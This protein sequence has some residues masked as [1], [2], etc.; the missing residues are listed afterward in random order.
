[1]I[2]RYVV[3]A[4]VIL[5]WIVG[6]EREPDQ[7]IAM[8]ILDVWSHNKISILAPSLWKYEVGNFVGRVIPDDAEEKMQYLQD[9]NIKSIELTDK[10]CF[11]CLNWMKTK[12]VT[13]YDASYLA[14]AFLA[15]AVLLTADEKFVRKMNEKKHITLLKNLAL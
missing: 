15:D 14:V 13:F 7:E 10:A 9:L 2:E 5:K 6:S 11:M 8:R 4:S 1:M 3:D 12:D